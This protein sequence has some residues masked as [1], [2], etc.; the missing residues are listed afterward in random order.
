MI[1]ITSYGAYIPRLRLNRSAIYQAMGWFAPA[2]IMVA[3]GERSMCNHDEDTLTMAV[4]AARDCL[5][6][7]DKKTVDAGY[8]CSTTLPFTDRQNAGILA[9]ALNLRADIVTA[10]FTSSLRAGTTGLLTALDV[11]RAGSRR[12]ILVTASDKRET[13]PASFYEMWFG[14]GAAALL[15]GNENVIAEFMGAHT[16]SY[17]FIDH[18]RSASA[19]FDYTWE[20][21]WLREEGYSKFIPEAVGAL[22]KKLNI[23]TEEVDHLVFPCFFKAEHRAIAKTLGVAPEKVIDTMHDVCGETGVAHPLLMLVAALERAKP[24]DGIIVAGFGQGCDALYFKVTENIVKL[25]SRRGV[26][27]SLENKKSIDNYMK[28]LQF[29]GL[30]QPEVGIRGEGQTQTAMTTLWRQRKMITGLVGGK[31]RD[32]GT[33]QYPKMDICVKPDCNHLHSQDDYEFADLPARIKTFTGDLLAVTIDPPAIY[34]MIQFEGGGRFMADFTDCELTGLKVGVPVR[35]SFRKKYSDPE[36][37]FAG[38][39]WKAV[40]QAVAGGAVF[41]I[42]F[43]DRVA[44]V[45]GAGGGLGRV[46]ALELARRGAKVVVND[47]GGARDGSGQGSGGPADEV[48]QEIREAG[49]EAVASYDSVTTPEGG[50][51]IIKTALDAFGRVDILINNAGILK[52]KS[53][54][55]MD[56]ENWRGV[57]DVHLNGAFHVTQPAF[58]V[59]RE[60]GYGRIIMTTSAAGLYGNFGQ[61]NYSTAK[62]ALVGL[63]NTLKLEG[64][65]YDIKVNTVAPIAATRLTADVLPADLQ[66]KMTPEFVAGFVVYLSSEECKESGIVMNVGAGFFSRAAILT[67]SGTFVGD[68]KTPPT[69]EDIRENWTKIN[70]M[71]GAGP[72]NDAG[73]AV[74]SFVT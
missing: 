53:F 29:R 8:L 51:N 33:P 19:R 60:R 55:K 54:T 64:E 67:G 1:G 23:S 24:G 42:R 49:G 59:M 14:D 22:L 61:A 62:M 30:L 72:L 17:D 28:F 57:M 71:E 18:Y 20:E 13:K 58:R 68:K 37:G 25:P 9:T 2:L 70:S 46:Y 31:C 34:G 35:M 11:V 21:R 47:F 4:A 16:V 56:L 38:Y 48:V 52:D 74:M 36:R 73:S 43:D 39:F 40:P 66:E 10:D 26:K 6:G 7:R 44:V 50:E 65:K 3:Q 41:D 15:V 69:P 32:C 27:G 12:H 63:M 5:T 45:T